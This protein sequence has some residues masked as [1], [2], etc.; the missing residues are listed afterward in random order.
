M[1]PVGV[2]V[3]TKSYRKVGR[4]AVAL[5]KRFT[6]LDV[7]VLSGADSE[8]F[9]LKLKLD[10]LVGK[11]PVIFFDADWWITRKTNFDDLVPTAGF[12]GVLDSAVFN[13]KAFPHTDCTHNGL[14]ST[15]Y[16]NTGFFCCDFRNVDVRKVFQRARRT[17]GRAK[18]ADVTDQFH[19]N[20][21]I[22]HVGVPTNLLPLSFNFYKKASDWGQVPFIPR[23]ILGLHA[24]G[25][26]AKDKFKKLSAQFE[27]FSEPV[28]PMHDDAIIHAY[29]RSFERL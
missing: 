15:R 7:I 12:Y 6:G 22:I 16:I 18:T 25:V 3:I 27:V 9:L 24:A 23:D 17:W 11:R 10:Q 8:G 29:S 5:F 26:C 14:D 13:P 2:T 28:G 1:K 21:A 20:A 19:I 4:R